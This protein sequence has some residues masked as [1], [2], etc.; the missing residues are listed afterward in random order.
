MNMASTA[1]SFEISMNSKNQNSS[2][3]HNNKQ[4]TMR[5]K[6]NLSYLSKP[7]NT[8]SR[9]NQHSDIYFPTFEVNSAN[10]TSK[11]YKESQR[12]GDNGELILDLEYDPKSDKNNL[13]RSYDFGD[14]RRTS[15]SDFYELNEMLVDESGHQIFKHHKG[16]KVIMQGLPPEEIQRR[17]RQQELKD[18]N[19]IKSNSKYEF[20]FQ[21]SRLQHIPQQTQN[22]K[23]KELHNQTAVNF[24]TQ[25]KTSMGLPKQEQKATRQI[26]N[27]KS[28][29]SKVKRDFKFT[30]NIKI[31]EEFQYQ[32]QQDLN[33]SLGLIQRPSTNKLEQFEDIRKI[34]QTVYKDDKSQDKGIFAIKSDRKFS[35]K[36]NRVKNFL[37]LKQDQNKQSQNS[38]FRESPYQLKLVVQNNDYEQ[39]DLVKT[40]YLRNQTPQ[41]QSLI[42]EQNSFQNNDLMA[43]K[44]YLRKFQG[45]D[46]KNFI[47][48]LNINTLQRKQNQTLLDKLSHHQLNKSSVIVLP[49]PRK[50]ESVSISPNKH[51]FNSFNDLKQSPT[52]I[53]NRKGTRD[54]IRIEGLS[55]GEAIPRIFERCGYTHEHQEIYR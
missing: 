27:F 44:E 19:E 24:F 32:G 23:V 9:N 46:Q 14:S 42:Y 48:D 8:S 35:D 30:R 20:M 1:H 50:Q 51:K 43:H 5:S 33:Q 29:L 25:R 49:S 11:K 36:F 47:I 39:Q 28:L 2:Q 21:L 41:P 18:L 34:N 45:L 7:S 54:D 16:Q 6:I 22:K 3:D 40:D 37:K 38:S 52:H 53:H 4:N 12:T 10:K 17:Q 13:N 15:Y 31:K 55:I 26:Q